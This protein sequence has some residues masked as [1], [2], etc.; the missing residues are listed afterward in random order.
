[1]VKPNMNEVSEALKNAQAI[2]QK[3]SPTNLPSY[4]S[5]QSPSEVKFRE[6]TPQE[7]E[8]EATR[9]LPEKPAKGTT[10][11]EKGIEIANITNHLEGDLSTLVPNAPKT[12]PTA[13]ALS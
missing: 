2:P 12:Q 7:Q 5:D 6:L 4:A 1:M 13:P 9:L 3:P 11:V 10:S 8:K